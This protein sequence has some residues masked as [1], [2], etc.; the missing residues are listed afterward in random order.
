MIPVAALLYSLISGILMVALSRLKVARSISVALSAGHLALVSYVA[1]E[2]FAHGPIGLQVGAWRAPFGISF[3]VDGLSAIMLWVSSFLALGV[4]VYSLASNDSEEDA[5]AFHVFYHFLMAGVCGAFT[6]NDL[7]N[8]FVWFEVLLISSFALLSNSTHRKS[9]SGSL[10]YVVI[11][12]LGSALFVLGLGLLYNSTGTLNMA[13]LMA[14]KSQGP[15]P[16]TMQIVAALFLFAFAMK[17]GVVP[18]A[19]WLPSSY[20]AAGISALA[21][22][23]G[24]LT[25]VGIYTLM[26]FVAL[27]LGDTNSLFMPL[28][29]A[30]SLATMLIGVLGAASSRS[31]RHILSYHIVSQVGYMTLAVSMGTLGAMAATIFYLAHHMVVK[32]SLFLA[33]GLVEKSYGVDELRALHR[34]EA[35]FMLF[36]AVPALSLAGLPPFSGFWAKLLVLREALS[37]EWWTSALFVLVVGLL[38][39]FS[40]SK[41]WSEVFQKAAD[42]PPPAPLERS[43]RLWLMKIPLALFCLWILMLGLFPTPFF[44][45]SS[46]AAKQ[47]M[48]GALNIS[49]VFQGAAP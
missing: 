23:A 25:K 2:V 22:F 19:Q 12:L 38:T 49:I 41:I 11:N 18:L 4:Q 26:R 17:A 37:L 33:A 43:S 8:L 1:Y 34:K 20:P 40:M 42:T 46:L 21:L 14:L 3:Y 13:D 47:L 39:L 15:L 45:L 24:L 9:F 5:G 36:F 29:T 10:V 27:G 44:E 35:L 28:L 32:T 6:T 30:A 7:F 16:A 48:D 31:W